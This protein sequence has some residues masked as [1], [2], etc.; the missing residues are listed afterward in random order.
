ML[1]RDEMFVLV[2]RLAAR[3]DTRSRLVDS[4]E[5]AF[6]EGGGRA[7]VRVVGGPELRL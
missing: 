5:T 1:P 3:E 4:L 2:D 7:F 6:A